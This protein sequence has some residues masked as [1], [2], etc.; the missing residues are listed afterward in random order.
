MKLVVL[1]MIL[2]FAIGFFLL[3]FTQSESKRGGYA[4][5]TGFVLVLAAGVLVAATGVDYQT[6]L[7]VTGSGATTTIIYDYT[8]LTATELGA[9]SLPLLLAGLWG[10]LVVW[11]ALRS[12]KYD[13][14]L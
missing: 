11:G 10:I 3:A 9:I 1:I 12:D 13:D 6:G 2:S 4:M 7:S 8:S 14:Q 5:M